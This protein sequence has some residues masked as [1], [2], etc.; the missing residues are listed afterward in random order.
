[1]KR[2]RH[3]IRPLREPF[4]KAGL[5]VAV[6]ALVL[7]MVGGAYA[8]G[9]LTGKQKKEVEKIAKKFAGK[10]GA[11]GATGQAGSAGPAGKNGAQ[12]LQGDPG[13]PGEPGPEG[14]EGSPW[15]AGGT[16]PPEAT[17][18]GTFTATAESPTSNNALAALS[19]PIPLKSSIPHENVLFV[20]AKD[21][22]EEKIPVG[23]SGTLEAPNAAPGNICVFEGL[24]ESV[25]TEQAPLTTRT[26]APVLIELTSQGGI[27]FGTWA[28]TAPAA[29]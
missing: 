20:T 8:A 17:E 9:A 27:T 28:A 15:T 1:M 3:P 18:T 12:G 16:L 14:P 7:A 25:A 2:L 26:G 11:P 19:F 21:V 6:I 23:C 10:P 24:P 5:T 29:P 22:E 13:Q 4:G